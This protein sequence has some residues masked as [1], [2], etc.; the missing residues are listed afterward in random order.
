MPGTR[1]QVR[2]EEERAERRRADREHAREAVERLRSSEGWRRWLATRRH[3]HAYSF[4][5]QL[6]IAMPGRLRPGSPGFRD[7]LKLGYVVQRGERS[8]KV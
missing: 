6:L 2:S 3:F 1:K 8:I 4:G 7:W 5:N